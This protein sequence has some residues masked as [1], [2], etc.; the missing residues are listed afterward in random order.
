MWNPL[1]LR[2][3]LAF[4]QDDRFYAL[5]LAAATTG[6]RRAELCG[7]RWQAIDLDA[8]TISVE[9][10][11]LVVVNGTAQ[12]SDGKTD[13][14]SRHL[15]LDPATITALRAWQ[16]AQNSERTFFDHGYLATDRVFTWENGR[17]VHPDVI[18][19]RFNRST[20]RCGLPPHPT[21]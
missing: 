12:D 6:L 21:V 15:A 9:P 20:Q 7:L 14:A 2:K 17:D 13:Q 1:Q 19:Q 10:D 18:R 11:T 16:E 4:I 3:F 8:I 5:Y